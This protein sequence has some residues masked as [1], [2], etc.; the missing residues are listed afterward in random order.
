MKKRIGRRRRFSK[1]S[2]KFNPNRNYV[3]NA[4]EEYLNKGGEIT[5]I[6]LDESSYKDFLA[7]KDAASVDRFL[8]GEE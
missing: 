6:E 8:A 5:K 3:Q 7:L 1:K 4:V 2:V